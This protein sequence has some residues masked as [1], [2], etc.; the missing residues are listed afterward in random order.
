MP[1]TENLVQ[2]QLQKKEKDFNSM[3][4][5]VDFRE[6]QSVDRRK[7]LIRRVEQTPVEHTVALLAA[8]DVL[9]RMHEEGL[10]DLINGLSSAVDAVVNH[11]VDVVSSKQMMTALRK[12]LIFSNLLSSI[13]PDQ[14][15]AVIAGDGQEPG[16]SIVAC[17][18]QEGNIEG[19]PS[20]P[21]G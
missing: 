12:A 2:I 13:D 5:A 14:L 7:N 18:W 4:I 16:D 15:H 1:G 3:A 20:M 8:Y 6:L 17:T 11:A 19:F 10:L 9:Q 21:G